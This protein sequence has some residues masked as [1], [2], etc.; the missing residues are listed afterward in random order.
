[1]PC[2]S[3]W[4]QAYWLC[5]Q[6]EAEIIHKNQIKHTHTHKQ[7]P[8]NQHDQKTAQVHWQGVYQPNQVSLSVK[9]YLHTNPQFYT[10]SQCIK[11]CTN[12]TFERINLT[13]GFK[14][15]LCNYAPAVSLEWTRMDHVEPLM[16]A[17]SLLCLQENYMTFQK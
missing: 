9:W 4:C 16:W 3:E 14:I 13:K 2:A 17:I 11:C 8:F 5:S 10:H 12:M 1:M 6:R 7:M 15:T